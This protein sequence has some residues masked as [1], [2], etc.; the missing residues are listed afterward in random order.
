MTKICVCRIARNLA[1]INLLA[2]SHACISD[3]EAD[4]NLAF[5]YKG[6]FDRF[7]QILIR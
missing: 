5:W 1:G 2:W 6:N 7:W 3:I 4:F